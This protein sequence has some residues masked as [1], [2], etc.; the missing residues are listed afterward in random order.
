MKSWLP[1]ARLLCNFI[2]LFFVPG[3]VTELMEQEPGLAGDLF[4]EESNC[5][6]PADIQIMVEVRREKYEEINYIDNVNFSTLRRD[7]FMPE[8]Q[9]NRLLAL[10][11]FLLRFNRENEIGLEQAKELINKICEKSTRKRL[12]SLNV[13]YGKLRTMH[14][15]FMTKAQQLLDETRPYRP[16]F[17]HRLII[18]KSDP[19]FNVG[20]FRGRWYFCPYCQAAEPVQ[21]PVGQNIQKT[22]QGAIEQKSLQP[23]LPAMQLTEETIKA[24]Y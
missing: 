6:L 1:I 13:L 11:W 21:Q 18:M 3:C 24:G 17:Y 12:Y 7:G 22:V 23:E 20:Y 5:N 15:E 14:E 9:F 16:W 2:I 8:D 19:G 4:R 10:R